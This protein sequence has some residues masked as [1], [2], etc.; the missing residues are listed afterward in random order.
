MAVSLG[1]LTQYVY[2]GHLHG[3][4]QGVSQSH[5]MDQMTIQL[6]QHCDLFALGPCQTV[7]LVGKYVLICR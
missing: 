2:Q 7:L 3:L 4:E 1:F 5:V 6:K